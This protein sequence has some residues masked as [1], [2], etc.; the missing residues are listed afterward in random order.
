[1][2]EVLI[3]I[4]HVIVALFMILVVLVQG[5]NEG[6]VGAAFGGGNSSG[7]FGA[8]GATSILGKLTY[9][10]A[11]IFMLTSITLTVLQGKGGDIGLKQRL[12]QQAGEQAP[13]PVAPSPAPVPTAK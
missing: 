12:K 5:G 7:V 9:G 6:G 2:A 1:M 10:A 4:I 13:A 3:E 11:G 8:T